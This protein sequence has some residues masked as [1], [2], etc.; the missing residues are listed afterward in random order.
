MTESQQKF[1]ELNHN[2][3]YSFLQKYHLPVEEWYGW[4]AIGLCKA[5]MTFKDDV[6]SFSTYAYRCMFTAVFQEK[7]KETQAG[8]IPDHQIFY[9]QSGFDTENDGETISFLET[10]PSNDDVEGDALAN[11]IFENFNNTLK[12][13]DRLIFEMFRNGYKQKEI[14]NAVGCSQSQVSRVKKKLEQHLSA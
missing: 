14:G 4:A 9:Y 6:S 12:P 7:R 3:I 1:V 10:M 8:T 2:L 5:A 11:V 13:R